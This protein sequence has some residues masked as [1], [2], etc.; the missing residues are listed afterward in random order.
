MRIIFSIFFILLFTY[1]I[2]ALLSIF[3]SRMYPRTFVYFTT[4][5]SWYFSTFSHSL[6]LVW[7]MITDLFLLNFMS[8]SEAHSLTILRALIIATRLVYAI[9]IS[10]AYAI[11]KI[12]RLSSFS[13]SVS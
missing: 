9:T 11:M 13:I 4:S 10:S 7:K 12:F 8:Y 5:M 2:F 6:N 3:L 1:S